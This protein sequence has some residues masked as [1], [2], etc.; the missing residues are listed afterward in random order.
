MVKLQL[1]MDTLDS[2]EELR[3]AAAKLKPAYSDK[4]V[5]ADLKSSSRY[6]PEI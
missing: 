4:T 5:L 2:N 6:I 3:H 1:I